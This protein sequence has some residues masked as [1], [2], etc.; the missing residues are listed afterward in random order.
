MIKQQDTVILSNT[1]LKGDYF[2]LQVKAE[3]IVP[4]V[5]PGQ[6]VHIKLPRF[7]HRILR[8]PFSI[9]NVDLATGVLSVIY[10]VVGEGTRYLSTLGAGEAVNII[11]PLGTAYSEIKGTAPILVA[12][13]YGCA[14][15]YLVAKTSAVPC[16]VLLG[17]RSEADLLLEEEFKALGCRVLVS[18]NDGSKGHRGFVTELLEQVLQEMPNG[19]AEVFACGP[20]PMLKATAMVAERFGVDAEVSLDQNMCCGVGACFACVIKKK[21]NNEDGWEYART[22]MTGPVFKASTVYWE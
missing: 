20:N 6:F 9:Y 4:E 8:R 10:K 19:T 11:G 17:G 12:G 7:E 1:R 14:A 2:L 16:T 15:T 18:T 3:I 21:A 22:C 5:K 13:G